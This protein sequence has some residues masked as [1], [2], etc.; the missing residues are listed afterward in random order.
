MKPKWSSDCL[1]LP[2]KLKIIYIIFRNIHYNVYIKTINRI[3][4]YFLTKLQKYILIHIKS[5]ERLCKWMNDNSYNNSNMMK[6]KAVHVY[7]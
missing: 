2:S 1:F 3:G 6:T 7:K 5:V 4:K